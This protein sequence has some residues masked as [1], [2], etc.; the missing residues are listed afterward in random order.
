MLEA[1]RNAT[2]T[3]PELIAAFEI[4]MSNI[5]SSNELLS[6]LSQRVEELRQKCISSRINNKR[7]TLSET[8]PAQIT[9]SECEA[10]ENGLSETKSAILSHAELYACYRDVDYQINQTKSSYQKVIDQIDRENIQLQ[11]ELERSAIKLTSLARQ[12]G[13]GTSQSVDSQ[14]LAFEF[15][16]KTTA[17]DGIAFQQF[18]STAANYGANVALW[19]VKS[20]QAGSDRN[21]VRFRRA[22]NRARVKIKGE[23]LHVKINRPWFKPSLFENTD[24]IFRV[25]AKLAHQCNTLLL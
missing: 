6:N 10:Y 25:S 14:W 12:T 2:H 1:L 21:G 22:M 23:L 11:L 8:E 16:S 20:T 19:S 18:S 13:R 17:I 9:T 7:R 4:L 3:T 5:S 15:D 24:L